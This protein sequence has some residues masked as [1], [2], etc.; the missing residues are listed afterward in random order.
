MNRTFLL[1]AIA[2]LVVLAPVEAAGVSGLYVEARTCD[3]W[4]GPCFANAEYGLSGHNAIL[5]WKIDRGE[6]DNVALDGLGVVA[7]IAASDT[8]GVKQTGPAKAVLIVDERATTA[9]RDALVRF[10]KR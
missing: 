7:V 5:A 3:I 9:Q 10:A 8:L 1:A 2:S 4:T 6:F